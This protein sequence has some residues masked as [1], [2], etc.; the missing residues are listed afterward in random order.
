MLQKVNHNMIVGFEDLFNM[1]STDKIDN[2]KY[3]P[4]DIIRLTENDYVIRLAVAGFTKDEL[5]IYKDKNNLFI[6]YDGASDRDVASALLNK[7]KINNISITPDTR[8]YDPTVYV[9]PE[10]PHATYIHNGI[11]RRPFTKTFTLKD[12]IEVVSAETKDGILSINLHKEPDV[13]TRKRI[14]I[15]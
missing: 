5:E 1:L 9:S 2:N 13:P 14:E 3:P 11:S 7:H 10:Y 6:S 4:H 12:G 8:T 15:K